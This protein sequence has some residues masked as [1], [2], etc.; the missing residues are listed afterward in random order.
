MSDQ[1]KEAPPYCPTEKE[2]KEIHEQFTYH[3]PKGNQAERYALLRDE[4]RELAFKIMCN[5]PPCADRSAAIRKLRECIM[6]ANAAIAC[7]E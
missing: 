2:E 7:N 4:A 6:T 3:P 5:V 1:N